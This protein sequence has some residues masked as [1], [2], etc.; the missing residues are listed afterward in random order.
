M[1]DL[2]QTP[3][4]PL[5]GLVLLF[6]LVIGHALADYPLQGDYIALHKN[7]HYRPVDGQEL[8]HGLWFHCLLAHCLIHAGF[9]WLISGRVIFA[10][11]EL[12]LHFVLDSL[13][14]ENKTS[15]HTD[16]MLHVFCKAL[17]VFAI[18]SAWV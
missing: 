8:P 9:V 17:Y 12:A 13:K 15:L 6:A 14:C 11:A 5:E 4:D 10:V 7:R 16:Q 18:M 3:H 2:T 1:L